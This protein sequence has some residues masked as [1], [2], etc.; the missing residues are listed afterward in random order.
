[1]LWLV[2][3]DLLSIYGHSLHTQSFCVDR[4]FLFLQSPQ[5]DHQS[6]FNTWHD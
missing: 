1:M 5:K 2:L 6:A 3:V 4:G